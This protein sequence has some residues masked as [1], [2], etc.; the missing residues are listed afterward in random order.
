MF[1]FASCSVLLFPG[2]PLVFSFFPSFCM[3]FYLFLCV[4]CWCIALSFR[5]FHMLP[6]LYSHVP[7]VFLIFTGFFHV[8]FPGTVYVFFCC[9]LFFLTHPVLLLFPSFP[10]TPHVFPVFFLFVLA[11]PLFSMC[12][13]CFLFFSQL[14]FLCFPL[15]YYVFYV[16][17]GSCFPVFPQTSYKIGHN[18]IVEPRS[19]ISGSKNRRN[20]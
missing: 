1:V 10:G 3:F 15:F 16:P 2:R 19:Q 20:T 14:M 6:L 12:F 11:P 18:C 17:M 13:L 9:L 7:Y 4:A 5:L 8:F